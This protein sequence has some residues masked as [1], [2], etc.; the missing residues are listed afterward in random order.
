MNIGVKHAQKSV[1]YKRAVGL[2]VHKRPQKNELTESDE[3]P[4]GDPL[5]CVTSLK[6]KRSTCIRGQN[7]NIIN[8]AVTLGLFM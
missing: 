5:Y 7:V 8:D 1:S 3:S 2:H 4:L 6:M